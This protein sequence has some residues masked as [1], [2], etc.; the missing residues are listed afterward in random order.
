MNKRA[1]LM[2]LAKLRQATRWTGYNCIADYHDGIYECDFVSPYTK[3]ANNVDAEILIM[4]QDWS[5][6]E[7]LGGPFDEDSANLGY[8]RHIPTNQNLIRLLH[9]NF[10]LTLKDTYATNL[11]PFVKLGGMSSTI[12]KADLI[13]AARHF[14]LPQILTVNPK[15]V[16][17]LGKETFNALRQICGLSPSPTVAVAIEEPFNLSE[18]RTRIWCQAHTGNLGRNNR[19]K[20]SID[21]VTDDWR[22]MRDDFMKHGRKAVKVKQDE[23]QSDVVAKKRTLDEI[24][25]QQLTKTRPSAHASTSRRSNERQ[26]PCRVIVLSQGKIIYETPIRHS[27]PDLHKEIISFQRRWLQKKYPGLTALRDVV[28]KLQW[29]ESNEWVFDR[30]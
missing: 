24:T 9:E 20:G 27:R 23:I 25:R 12:R 8:S 21:R 13:A 2:A 17:C 7:S 18:S 6:D 30:Q 14:A 1:A 19:N 10:G 29:L 22:R 5:S 4:L 15:L 28:Y 3:S 26:K 11:F 16:I